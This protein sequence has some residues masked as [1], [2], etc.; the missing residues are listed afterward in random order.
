MIVFISFVIAG[1]SHEV[2]S[3][4]AKTKPSDLVN[5]LIDTYDSRFDFFASATLPFGMVSLSP[6]T[7]H[8]NLWSAGNLYDYKYILNFSHIQ[9]VTWLNL[10]RILSVLPD[11]PCLYSQIHPGRILQKSSIGMEFPVFLQLP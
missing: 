5:P 10:V 9:K 3:D 4:D 7:K 11:T 1:C 6:D 8:G 2:I